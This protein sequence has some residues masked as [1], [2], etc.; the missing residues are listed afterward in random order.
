MKPRVESAP[1][2]APTVAAPPGVS[3]RSAQAPTATPPAR[4]AFWRCSMLIR[5]AGDSRHDTIT[6]AMVQLDSW[7]QLA[8]VGNSCP[9]VYLQSE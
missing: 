8:I 9:L 4:V 3:M 6:V 5:R 7:Q 2:M 1:A